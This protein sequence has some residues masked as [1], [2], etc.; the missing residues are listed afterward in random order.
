M[1]QGPEGWGRGSYSLIKA[2]ALYCGGCRWLWK[3][4]SHGGVEGQAGAH[5]APGLCLGRAPSSAGTSAAALP[6]NHSLIFSATFCPLSTCS[7]L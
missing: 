1:G 4:S 2:P 5:S 6:W 7:F 3:G